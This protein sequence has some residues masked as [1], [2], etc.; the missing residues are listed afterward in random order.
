MPGAGRQ[1]RTRE[2]VVYELVEVRWC[3]E[4]LTSTSRR[5]ARLPAPRSASFAHRRNLRIQGNVEQLQ[6]LRVLG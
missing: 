5:R 1:L 6:L 4:R 2:P 3:C